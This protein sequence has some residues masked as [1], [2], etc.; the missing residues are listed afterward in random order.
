MTKRALAILVG[1]VIAVAGAAVAIA[2]SISGSDEPPVHTLPGGEVHTGQ[3]PSTAQETGENSRTGGDSTKDRGKG[4][5]NE[6]H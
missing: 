3:M 6:G 2:T 5:M 4:G 1:V